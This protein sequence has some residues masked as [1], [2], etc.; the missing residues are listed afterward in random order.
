MTVSG[1]TERFPTTFANHAKEQSQRKGLPAT[2]KRCRF[3]TG[4]WGGKIREDKEQSQRKGLPATLKRCRLRTGI[5][6]E[7]MTTIVKKKIG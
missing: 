6:T 1:A 4:I 2:L 3:R 5:C 7:E